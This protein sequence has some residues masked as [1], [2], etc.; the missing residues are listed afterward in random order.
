MMPRLDSPTMYFLKQKRFYDNFKIKQEPWVEG[1]SRFKQTSAFEQ[2][3]IG[4]IF[5]NQKNP[6]RQ[7]QRC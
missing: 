3:I 4:S 1:K 7:M 2:V 5:G 6:F